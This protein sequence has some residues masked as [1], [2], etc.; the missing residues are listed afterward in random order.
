[1]APDVTIFPFDV[2]QS[3]LAVTKTILID[4]TTPGEII[5][6]KNSLLK[7]IVRLNSVTTKFQMY[8]SVLP[9]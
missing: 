6:N 1:V 3:A 8:F 9:F 2:P 4:G 7:N 5:I